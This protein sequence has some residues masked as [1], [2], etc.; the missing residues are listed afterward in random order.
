[1]EDYTNVTFTLTNKM[2]FLQDACADILTNSEQKALTFCEANHLD[3]NSLFY[4]EVCNIFEAFKHY[5]NIFVLSTRK[6]NLFMEI[7]L[8]LYIYA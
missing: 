1:M 7:I 2:H 5:N 6:K 4:F 3:W 8:P